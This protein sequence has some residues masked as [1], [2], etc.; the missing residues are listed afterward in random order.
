MYFVKT[1]NKMDTKNL[2]PYIL[3]AFAATGILPVFP[4]WT[5]K[6]IQKNIFSAV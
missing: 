1:I 6:S 3:L 2:K 5:M 4:L